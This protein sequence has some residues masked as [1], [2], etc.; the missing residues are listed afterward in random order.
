MT[1][2]Q[3]L[4]D[5]I[6][7]EIGQ[8]SLESLGIDSEAMFAELEELS[9]SV[10]LQIEPDALYVNQK[11][12]DIR[13]AKRRAQVLFI[14]TQRALGT[15]TTQALNLETQQDIMLSAK[16]SDDSIAGQAGYAAQE[17]LARANNGLVPF[18]QALREAKNS[19][20]VLK[21]LEKSIALCNRNLEGTSKDIK[22]Q[23]SYLEAVLYN[24]KGSNAQ[25]NKA[26]GHMKQTYKDLDELDALYEQSIDTRGSSDTAPIE[27]SMDG[28]DEDTLEELDA[29]VTEG[30][31]QD[32]TVDAEA[33]GIPDFE[34]KGVADL[35]EGAMVGNDYSGSMGESLYDDSMESFLQ[36]SASGSPE[37]RLDG[38]AIED[39]PSEEDDAGGDVLLGTKDHV[40]LSFEGIAEVQSL[41][42]DEDFFIEIDAGLTGSAT[43]EDLA[44]T[45]GTNDGGDLMSILG[46]VTDGLGASAEATP[47]EEPPA[48]PEEEDVVGDLGDPDD[49]FSNMVLDDE[50]TA[51]SGSHDAPPMGVS[52]DGPPPVRVAVS[53][54]AVATNNTYRSDLDFLVA[55]V[56][57]TPAKQPS[58]PAQKPSPVGVSKEPVVKTSATSKTNPPKTVLPPK[59]PDT[60]MTVDELFASLGFA[61]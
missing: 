40:P 48:A 24:L 3:I 50:E 26:A 21:S 32:Y 60:L 30:T 5:N 54:E 15:A 52:L 44:G 18:K 19:V 6:E 17:R 31:T 49:F 35:D 4:L 27:I 56:E 2:E 14:R 1:N 45:E 46:S 38:G 7:K 10:N 11:L 37:A 8:L 61:M 42:D 20:T 13:D 22:A 12:V 34:E 53:K 41:G 59:N 28:A 47:Y 23:L 33:T 57:E 25:S 51:E 9:V 58:A 36:L 55:S 43:S 29:T 39:Y 16:L